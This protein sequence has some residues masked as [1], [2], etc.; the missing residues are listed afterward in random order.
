MKECLTGELL[1]FESDH[2]WVSKNLKAILTQYREQWI[3]VKNR[4]VI[5]SDR[6]L[7]SL[8]LKIPDPSHTCIEFM[9]RDPMETVL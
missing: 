1:A 2:V 6:L 9:T 4:K 3:A 7:D 5:A 8:L